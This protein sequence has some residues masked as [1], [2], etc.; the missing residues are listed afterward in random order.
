MDNFSRFLIDILYARVDTTDIKSSET[1]NGETEMTTRT[2][3]DS[4]ATK[5]FWA[6][7]RREDRVANAKGQG[8][9]GTIYTSRDGGSELVC[10][11]KAGHSDS[12]YADGR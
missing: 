4:Q 9:C 12:H 3:T 10:T 6:N 8:L 7:I 1:G 11:E 5:D 2:R